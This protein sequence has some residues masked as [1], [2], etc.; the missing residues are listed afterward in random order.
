MDVKYQVFIS[1]TFQDLENE[2][3]AAIESV[4]NLGHIPVGMELF[5]AGDDT[6]WNYI[7]RRIMECDYYLVIVAERYGSE[8]KGKS[9]T[10]M[11]YE[12]ALKNKKPV[13]AFLLHNDAR[14]AWPQDRVEF[15][16]K[17]KVDAFRSLCQRKLVRH[18]RS[19]DDL[20]A[21]IATT[22]VELTREKPQ[23]GWVRADSVP[24]QSVLTEIA[25]L[26]EEKRELQARLDTLGKSNEIVIPA[27][28]RWRLGS[29][30]AKKSDDYLALEEAS[31]I[32]LSLIDL[33]AALSRLFAGGCRSWELQASIEKAFNVK[34]VGSWGATRS[35]IEELAANE[36]IEV[37]RTQRS[38]GKELTFEDMYFLTAYGKRL[39]M[40]AEV[41]K[42]T[43][44]SLEPVPKYDDD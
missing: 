9:Y 36:V 7:K 21:K 10:Q 44:V 6:Q 3:R 24:S 38:S 15:A 30:A 17:T 19:A 16:K 23:V 20:A 35:F 12:F 41:G 4:L 14:A 40:Y 34:F 29:L 26:S 28:E 32:N 13:A 11:E 1:S 39:I 2:R 18:W 5:Q 33:L 43:T 25:R 37:R 27:E 22:L 42:Y 31:H 8:V